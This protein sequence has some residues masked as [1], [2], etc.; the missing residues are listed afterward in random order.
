MYDYKDG[1]NGTKTIVGFIAQDV[2]KIIPEAIEVRSDTLP[3]LRDENAKIIGDILTMSITSSFE[4]DDIIDVAS[5][6]LKVIEVLDEYNYKVQGLKT[7]DEETKVTVVGQKVD[8]FHM[9]RKDIIYS[10]GI[11]AIQELS[12][13]LNKALDRIAELENKITT[14]L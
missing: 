7:Y 12:R 13:Q 14:L 3:I 10:Y 1:R 2:Q 6:E 5:D 11:S 4:V 8:D 9:L